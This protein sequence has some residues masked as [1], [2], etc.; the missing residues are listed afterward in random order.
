MDQSNLTN[1]NRQEEEGEEGEESDGEDVRMALTLEEHQW[2]KAIRS[3]VREDAELDD[4]TDY[5]YALIALVDKDDVAAAV[6]RVYQLQGFRQQYKA[7][8]TLQCARQNLEFLVNELC[9]GFL[10]NLDYFERERSPVVMF[11]ASKIDIRELATHE[12]RQGYL[13][14]MY[15]LNDAFT[16]DLESARRG[17]IC[18]T[19][20]EGYDWRKNASLSLF[21]QY[22]IEVQSVYPMTF[23]KLKLFRSGL[24]INSLLSLTKRFIPLRTYTNFSLGCNFPRRLDEMCLQPSREEASKRV[25][26]AIHRALKRRHHNQATFSL[27]D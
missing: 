20:C 5:E 23:S 12:R 13:R 8:G 10:L 9:P 6:E 14:A 18:L 15:Y 2:A 11:D 7:T 21:H 17:T 27:G 4:L 26:A 24:F 3:A 25:L 1:A 19:E 22:W 16:A